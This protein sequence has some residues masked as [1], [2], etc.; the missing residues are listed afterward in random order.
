MEVLKQYQYAGM[1]DPDFMMMPKIRV[2]A[3][4]N[5]L[6]GGNWRNELCFCSSGKK[7]KRCCGKPEWL[8]PDQCILVNSY[9]K[10]RAEMLAHALGS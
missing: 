3:V 4:R 5:V 8:T 2:L 9:M 10:R 7:V 1:V 6:N